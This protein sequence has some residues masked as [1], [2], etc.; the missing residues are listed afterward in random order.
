MDMDISA[1]LKIYRGWI[2]ADQCAQTV[3]E[4]DGG[5]WLEHS[6][7]VPSQDKGV[8][9]SGS[10]ELTVSCKDTSTK[11]YLMQRIWDGYKA[12][13]DDLN[14]EWF[15]GWSGYSGLRFNKYCQ[16]QLMSLHCDHISNL[17]D[18]VK[19]GI[20]TMSALGLLNND[21]EG[22]EFIM[23]DRKIEFNAGDL[24]IFPSNFL[25]PHKVDPITKG[26]RYSFVSWSW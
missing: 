18:G 24:M 1:Y 17:F 16:D 7:Y 8:S 14:F 11:P 22:G 26:E 25:Y 15:R 6:F 12:Y 9:L 20:P 19:K 21:Y 13:I 23:W 10:R 3:N 4:L 2:D 5:E